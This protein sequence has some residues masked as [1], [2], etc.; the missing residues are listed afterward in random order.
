MPLTKFDT[1]LR[2]AIRKYGDDHVDIAV[3]ENRVYGFYHSSK[4]SFGVTDDYALEEIGGMDALKKYEN[5]FE[6]L[7][8]C[9]D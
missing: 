1:Q 3:E 8:I 6:D 9:E 2:D 4:V 5:E 7:C